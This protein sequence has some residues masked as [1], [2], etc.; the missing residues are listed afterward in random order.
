[1][2]RWK[3]YIAAFLCVAI[4]ML[5]FSALSLPVKAATAE[6]KSTLDFSAMPQQDNPTTSV[7]LIK[8]AGAVDAVNLFVAGNYTPVAN[9][10]G[11]MGEG[12]YIQKLD[13]GNGNVFQKAY[14]DLIYWVGT[15]EPQGY[16][17]VYAS[18]DNNNYTEVFAQ[19][20]GNGDPWVE[21]TRQS[22]TIELP[23]AK[24]AK[25]VYIKVVMQHWTTWEGAAVKTSTLRGVVEKHDN[26]TPPPTTVP[27]DTPTKEITA[28]FDFSSMATDVVQ[29]EVRKD[30]MGYGL[31]DCGNVQIGGNYGNVATPGGYRGEGFVTHKLSA[32][33][34]QTLVSAKLDLRYW[35]Y[36][37]AGSNPGYLKVMAST[38]GVTFTELT[39]I[40][41]DTSKS[42]VQSYVVDLPM[43]AGAK[44]IYVKV[45]MQHWESYEGAAVK[46]I[47]ITGR[48]PAEEGEIIGG[49]TGEKHRVEAFYAFS[50]L[51]FGEVEAGNIG[52]DTESN[53]YFGIDGVALLT[54]RG[55]YETAYAVWKLSAPKGETLDDAMF[56]FVGRTWYMTPDQKDNNTLKV[57]VS[58][59]GANYSE[60]HCY[61][62]N[63]EQSDT[64]V[65][66]LDLTEHVSGASDVY[67]KMEWLLFDSP[68]VM[69]IRS[70]TLIGNR[71]GVEDNTNKPERT[72]VS[73]VKSFTSLKPGQVSAS[74]IQAVKSANLVF[75]QNGTPLLTAAKSGQDAFAVWELRAA[76]G[77]TFDNCYLTL[78]G[79][80]TYSDVA[81][82]DY[83]F[84]KILVSTDGDHYAEVETLRPVADDSDT[85]KYVGDLSGYVR[86]CSKVYVK[87]FLFTEEDPSVMGL[88][89]LSLV[90]N[91]GNSY[92]SYTP[93]I[94]DVELPQPEP[95]EPEQTEPEQSGPS[96]T[97]PTEE[98]KD[99]APQPPKNNGLSGGVIALIA[100]GAVALLAGGL[101]VGYLLGR[102][103]TKET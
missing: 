65:F 93:P 42:A 6:V 29:E 69:G 49:E 28:K 22:R 99:P 84:M 80:I 48:I 92:D 41:G 7:Q 57:L 4:M 47:T 10:G 55:G 56:R 24:D 37:A 23:M 101:V 81:K 95:T 75:G 20:E 61:K 38:D 68:H 100:A 74:G 14:L 5:C 27:D 64:Q 78:V 83:T 3:R 77:E 2:E 21:T 32:P 46:K 66:E 40:N 52:A 86:G 89:S 87:L 97:E 1:M 90:G 96:A 60:V 44:E 59:D 79:K 62:S 51:A 76:E 67:V 54:P 72:P 35:A 34:G 45:A 102:K 31:H 8:E 85:L 18:T 36:N 91:A 15:A 63:D 17:K 94:E 43:A 53:M 12:Y 58:T 16:L 25:T 9:P 71:N 88:R 98:Q 73:N 11:Y 103:R 19:T 82:K 13:A 50:D 39:Q 70:V 26:P 33:A 30:L